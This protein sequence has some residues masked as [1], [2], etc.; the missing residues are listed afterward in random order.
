MQMQLQSQGQ[1]QE[2]VSVANFLNKRET[3]R[4]LQA[5]LG[6]RKD[7]FTSTLIALASEDSLLAQCDPADLLKCAMNSVSLN[8]PLNKSL[9]YAYAVPYKD[10]KTGKV[11]PQFQLGYKGLIQMAVRSGAYQNINA[12]SVREGELLYNKFEGTYDFLGESEGKVV[13]YFATFT[14][15]NGFKKSLFMTT[16]QIQAHRARYS[17]TRF[18]SPWDS[19]FE[20]MA[21][22][23]VLKKLLLTY[24]LLT[25]QQAEVLGGEDIAFE[26]ETQEPK[27]IVEMQSEE[28]TVKL[29]DI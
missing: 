12:C 3:A 2:P 18:N 1:R 24:G 28:P 26:G 20:E 5:Q 7:A 23:T 15:K 9:G 6:E 17:K 4:F 8:L 21:Q 14:L 25:A 13:G 10:G 29:S 19:S 11:V 16:E 22:K 27:A